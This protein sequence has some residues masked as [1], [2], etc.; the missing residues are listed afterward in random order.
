MLHDVAVAHPAPAAPLGAEERLLLVPRVEGGVELRVGRVR[1]VAGGERLLRGDERGELLL[2]LREALLRGG[3][4]VR[5]GVAHAED[6]V[7]DDLL[8]GLDLAEVELQRGDGG[9]GGAD[10]PRAAAL[11]DGLGL[12]ELVVGADEEVLRAVEAVDLPVGGEE[13]R[14]PRVGRHER[15]L[16]EDRH[17]ALRVEPRIAVE[18]VAV[19][20]EPPHVLER[21]LLVDEDREVAGAL[22]REAERPIFRGLVAGGDEDAERRGD[23][24]RGVLDDRVAE[25]VAG[26]EARGLGLHG[27]PADVPERPGPVVADVDEAVEERVAAVDV[28]VADAADALRELGHLEGADLVVGVAGAGLLDVAQ[29]LPVPEHVVERAGRVGAGDD[30]FEAVL[31]EMAAVGGLHGLDGSDGLDGRMATDEHGC[32]HNPRRASKR[33]GRYWVSFRSCGKAAEEALS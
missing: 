13:A 21:D 24:V 14:L 32:Y 31:G 1:G 30:V 27:L 22:R 6:E 11:H 23:A 29:E 4:R 19:G 28:E 25:A 9:V 2:D 26:A 15:V 7:D 5:L 16:R 3:R 18:H 20:V 10:G 12:V 8:A 33:K 17:V